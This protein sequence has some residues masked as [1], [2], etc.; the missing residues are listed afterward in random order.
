MTID[1][2]I[3]QH[4]SLAVSCATAGEWQEA[5]RHAHACRDLAS[6]GSLWHVWALH[7]LACTYVDAGRPQLAA[8]FARA[9]FR[10]QP[11]VPQLARFVPFVIRALSHVAYQQRRFL[12]AVH[13]RRRAQAMFEAAGNA[14]QANRTALNVAWAYARA[15][16]AEAARQA[17]PPSVPA[18]MEHLLA[19]AQAAIMAAEERWTEAAEAGAAAL[20]GARLADDFADAAE[21][22]LIVSEASRRLNPSADQALAFLHTA[23]TFA[24]RQ[25]R[26]LHS[27]QV[28]SQRAGGGEPLYVHAATARGSADLH[29]CGCYSTGVA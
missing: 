18:A 27:L 11:G 24:A 14:E 26:T 10:L 4:A 17:L 7:M 29:H 6:A 16:R 3:R 8:V 21:V 20:Q 2:Q 13:L 15:G 9:F 23:A 5:L 19:G 12:V 1:E 22:C 25:D 28:L